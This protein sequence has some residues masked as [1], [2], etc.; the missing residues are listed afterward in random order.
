M[1]GMHLR[2]PVDPQLERMLLGEQEVER[3]ELRGGP[4]AEL[5]ERFLFYGIRQQGKTGAHSVA[6][7]K[8]ARRPL[9]IPGRHNLAHVS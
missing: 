4:R 2:E 5:V 6:F 3:A 1:S 8:A 9:G 7:E